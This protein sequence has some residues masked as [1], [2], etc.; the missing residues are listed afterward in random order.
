MEN[1]QL[2]RNRE[3]EARIIAYQ[4]KHGIKVDEEKAAQV[5][6]LQQEKK[7]EQKKKR[8][9][10]KKK[11]IRPKDEKGRARSQFDIPK[12][13]PHMSRYLS[14][15][16][17]ELYRERR[18]EVEDAEHHAHQ[19]EI[20]EKENEIHQKSI[21]S[22]QEESGKKQKWRGPKLREDFQLKIVDLGNACW[23]HHHFSTE[24]QTRQYRS[25]EV[26]Y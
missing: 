13:G 5:R 14:L 18:R 24:I 3:Y 6:K 2:S 26:F 25:P 11:M 15:P 22:L 10:K 16:E 23:K 20:H 4:Q 7:K 9:Q 21:E 1:G 8:K 17:E 19:K 12:R